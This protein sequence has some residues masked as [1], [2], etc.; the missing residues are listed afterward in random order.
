MSCFR[1]VKEEYTTEGVWVPLWTTREQ[2]TVFNP[3]SA[4]QAV[5]KN[6]DGL[7][8]GAFVFFDGPLDNLTVLKPNF[9]TPWV[10]KKEYIN[11]RGNCDLLSIQTDILY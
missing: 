7:G 6:E 10:L 2:E 3:I 11:N 5:P 8:I 4:W 1:C 9:P